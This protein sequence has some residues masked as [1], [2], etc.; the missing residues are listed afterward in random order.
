LSLANSLFQPIKNGSLNRSIVRFVTM[1]FPFQANKL[2]YPLL[3][4]TKIIIS[5]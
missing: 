4:G 3:A 1:L 2:M 5:Q